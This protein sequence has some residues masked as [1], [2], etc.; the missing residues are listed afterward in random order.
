MA[1]VDSPEAG[2]VEG[3]R[4]AREMLAQVRDQV[5]GV[6]VSAPFGKYIAAAQVLGLSEEGSAARPDA[7]VAPGLPTTA[8]RRI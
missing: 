1:A 3:V 5:Q 8:A 2:R 7:G 4:I 6:Q